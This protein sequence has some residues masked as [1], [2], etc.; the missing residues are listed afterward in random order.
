MRKV[1]FLL[2]VA[3][4][5][6]LLAKDVLSCGLERFKGCTRVKKVGCCAPCPDGDGCCCMRIDVWLPTAAAYPVPESVYGANF[7]TGFGSEAQARGNVKIVKFRP[8]D[9]LRH[10]YGVDVCGRCS[11][12]KAE[13]KK[14]NTFSNSAWSTSPQYG[15]LHFLE[16]E[17]W[18]ELP[19]LLGKGVE[20]RL[21]ASTLVW[22]VRALEFEGISPSEYYM[23]SSP[24]QNSCPSISTRNVSILSDFVSERSDVWSNYGKFLNR[25]REET[26]SGFDRYAFTVSFDGRCSDSSK[27]LFS[28]PIYYLWEHYVCCVEDLGKP[29]KPRE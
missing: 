22:L 16:A 19:N 21:F 9:V 29:F 5:L 3:A 7:L 14:L 25:F 8:E 2:F 28:R 18:E 4:A 26:Y 24:Y 12:I 27:G 17:P 10:G 1:F 13:I 15:V 11:P 20:D 23:S 6:S